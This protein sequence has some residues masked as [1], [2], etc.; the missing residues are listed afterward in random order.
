MLA[1]L[2]AQKPPAPAGWLPGA[3]KAWPRSARVA[4]PAAPTTPM[5]WLPGAQKAQVHSRLVAVLVPTAPMLGRLTAYQP[6]PVA[7]MMPPV[8]STAELWTRPTRRFQAELM[9]PQP[10][11]AVP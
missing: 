7:L 9:V 2:T 8:L 6:S 4:L 10:P 3:Q 5:L 1:W 11:T